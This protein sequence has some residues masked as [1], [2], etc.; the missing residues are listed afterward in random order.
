M[1]GH[2]DLQGQIVICDRFLRDGFCV[3]G[4]T[5]RQSHHHNLSPNY[6]KADKDFAAD[7]TVS[8]D[9][10]SKDCYSCASKG[11]KVSCLRPSLVSQLLVYTPSV[12][13]SR[14]QRPGRAMHLVPILRW[15]QARL[16]AVPR[17]RVA[18]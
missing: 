3:L 12:R 14:A 11:I 18:K 8:T 4:D 9:K 13:P 10:S 15:T 5:C 2:V 17:E 1:K 7:F 16:H 6:H